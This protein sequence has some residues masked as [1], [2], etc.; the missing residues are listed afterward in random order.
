[1]IL[2]LV[3]N[4]GSNFRLEISRNGIHLVHLASVLPNLAHDLGFVL[5]ANFPVAVNADVSAGVRLGHGILLEERDLG[6][7]VRGKW[8]VHLTPA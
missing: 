5:A 2:P 4:G 7:A 8:G 3:S 6:S 1:V